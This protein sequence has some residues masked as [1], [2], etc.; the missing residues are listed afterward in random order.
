MFSLSTGVK[1]S[2]RVGAKQSQRLC[3]S[4]ILLWSVG[5]I[6]G[7]S[8]PTCVSSMGSPCRDRRWHR[9]GRPGEEA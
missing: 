7:A 1:D 2:G 9:S 5:S 8:A 3:V 6:Y 4:V